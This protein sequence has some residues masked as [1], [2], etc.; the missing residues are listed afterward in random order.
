MYY[1]LGVSLPVVFLSG[2]R[3]RGKITEE[4]RL[5]FEIFKRHRFPPPETLFDA[6]YRDNK[7]KNRNFPE[8]NFFRQFSRKHIFSPVNTFIILFLFYSR[9]DPRAFG[10]NH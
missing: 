6:N 4:A 2:C 1:L 5:P 8:Q 3:Q 10:L 7:S 9:F